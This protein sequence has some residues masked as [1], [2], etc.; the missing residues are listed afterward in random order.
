ME[1]KQTKCILILGSTYPSHSKTHNE[2]VCTGGIEDDTCRM[3]RLHPVPMRYLE[4]KH[5]FQKFQWIEAKV[6]RHDSDP[7]PESYRIDPHSIVLGDV[8]G[9][10]EV[11][12]S[13][14]E[15]S[16]HLIESVE[17][18]KEKQAED[19]T[20]LG[21]IMPKDILN[22]S[23]EFRPES[24][25]S[26]WMRSEEARLSQ[27][28]LFGESVKPLDFPEARFMV[29][30]T[31]NDA[32]CSNHSM[33]ILQWGIHELY[34]K[35]KNDEE[36]EAKMLNAMQKQLDQWQRDVFL[37]LGNFRGIQYNFGLMD[38]YSA[39][40]RNSNSLFT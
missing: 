35:L 37:F 12:R 5:R 24:E 9:N 33:G 20:S 18:L 36:C 15:N 16:P 39:P 26:E 30:W 25:R 6:E 38:S 40:A 17:A 8:V 4:A 28:N 23:L 1:R 13:Y 7:R 22:C 29:D 34:R 32:R 3:V 27:Q 21:I 31:C 2:I 19:G 14:L 11:R 10:H